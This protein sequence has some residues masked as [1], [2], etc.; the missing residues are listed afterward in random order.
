M[1]PALV[2]DVNTTT[3]TKPNQTCCARCRHGLVWTKLANGKQT[4]MRECQTDAYAS[5]EAARKASLRCALR[6][7]PMAMNLISKALRA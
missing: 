4:Q 5:D 1:T 3:Q 2:G 6:A 7:D